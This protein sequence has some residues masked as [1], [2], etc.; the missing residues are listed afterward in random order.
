[1]TEGRPGGRSKIAGARMSRYPRRLTPMTRGRIWRRSVAP[2]RRRVIDDLLAPR[3]EYVHD[4]LRE[5]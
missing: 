2:G 5:R 3:R 1:M 4:G